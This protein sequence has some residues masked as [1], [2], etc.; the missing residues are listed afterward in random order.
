M[1]RPVR[2]NSE[3]PGRCAFCGERF[4]VR[5][6]QTRFCSRE[7]GKAFFAG[8]VDGAEGCAHCAHP[9]A[10]HFAERGRCRCGCSRFLHIRRPR[11]KTLFQLHME[12]KL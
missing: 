6:K 2:P 7:C 3:T 10:D 5:G 1:A 12:G 4:P 9:R 8:K 11:G